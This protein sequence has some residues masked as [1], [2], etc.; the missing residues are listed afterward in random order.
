MC[1][2]NERLR[3]AISVLFV[4]SGICACSCCGFSAGH[5]LWWWS[6]VLIHLTPNFPPQPHLSAA[7]AVPEIA[8]CLSLHPGRAAQAALGQGTG[9]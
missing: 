6:A 9:K 4:P 7:Q 5:H 2:Q 1:W 8:V 3:L